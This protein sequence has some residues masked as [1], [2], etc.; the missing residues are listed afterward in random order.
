MNKFYFSFT[1]SFPF[2]SPS[3]VMEVISEITIAN[4]YIALKMP[5]L[6]DSAFIRRFHFCILEFIVQPFIVKCCELLY[7]VFCLSHFICHLFDSR[8][9]KNLCHYQ[10]E[11][12]NLLV[13]KAY[14]TYGHRH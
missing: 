5:F 3:L 7:S 9:K 2:N 8:K 4:S 13:Y 1:I 10:I 14:P 6:P 12:V 11:C